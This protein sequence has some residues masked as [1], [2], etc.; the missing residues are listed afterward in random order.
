MLREIRATGTLVPKEN[1][2]ITAGVA[3]TVQELLAQPGERV[4]ADTVIARLVNSAAVTEVQRA[5]AALAG[6]VANV[7]A[8]RSE[9]ELQRLEQEAS[10]ARA[11]STLQ[12]TRAKTAA[13]TRAEQAGVVSLMELKQSQITEEQDARLASAERQRSVAMRS[14]LGAQ[15]L[16]I[17]ALRDESTSALEIARRDEE[18]LQ[19]R[20]GI[21]GIVQ[22][23]SVELGEQVEVGK[24]LARVAKHDVLIARLLVPEIQAKDLLLDLPCQVDLH[25]GLVKGRINRIDPAVREGRVAVDVLFDGPLPGGARPDLTVEG[26]IVLSELRDV[27]NIARPVSAMANGAGTL[28]VIKPG[29]KI[30]QRAKVSYGATSSDRIEVRSGLSAGDQVIL[31]DTEQWS[32]FDKLRLN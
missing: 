32:K 6:A 26:R 3:G 30:A 8:K 11:E 20:A 31:S 12:I 17:N 28:F 24:R 19:V 5:R 25:V 21:T 29:E 27:V 7:T 23:I 22:E 14:N 10:L 1:R 15:M 2:W 13:L 4:Q 9:L 18:Q 16:A